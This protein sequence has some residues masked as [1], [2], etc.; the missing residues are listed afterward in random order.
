MILRP[1]YQ[2]PA[3]DAV[4]E[5]L[6]KHAST[7]LVMAT[8][9]GKCLA[10]GTKVLM[11]DGRPKCVEDIDVG[12]LL[13]GP[14]SLP[15]EVTTTAS[16]RDHMFQVT[17]KKGEP[18]TVNYD[19]V[20]CIKLTA[21]KGITKK[22]AGY[23][24]GD[25]IDM[26]LSELRSMSKTFQHCAKGF[27]VG[28]DFPERGLPI[29]PYWLGLWLGDGASK[30]SDIHNT[31]PEIENYLR[32]FGQIHGLNFRK[33]QYNGKCPVY[34][35][36]GKKGQ[37]SPL[38]TQLRSLG[39]LNN[40]HIP[41]IYKCNS[42]E[43][44]LFLLAGL[45]DSD[46]Y[47]IPGGG[48]EITVKQQVFAEDIAYLARSL[49][50]AAYMKL[51][52]A[53][54]QTGVEGTYFRVQI[55]GD[56]SVIPTLI[57]RKKSPVRRQKKDVLVHG[58]KSKYIGDGEYFGFT[59]DRDGR[60]LLGDFTVTH[61]TVIAAE[62]IKRFYERTGRSALFL[63]DRDHL[64]WQSKAAIE[65]H[66]GL[67]VGV[68]M[69]VHRAEHSLF[70]KDKVIVSTV[71][72]QISGRPKKR[73]ERF[74]PEEF[75][76]VI[77]DECHQSA[78]PTY[79]TIWNH[80]RQN[81]NI[82]LLGITAT[83]VRADGKPLMFEST[84]FQYGIH[85]GVEDGWLVDVAQQFI[86]VDSLDWSECR[87]SRN[88]EFREED[89]AKVVET[90][91]NIAGICHPSLEVIF[92]L[93]PETLSS[94]PLSEWP[95]FLKRLGKVP[96]RTIIFT[97]SV[98]QAE[99]CCHILNTAYPG[100]AE[101]V[102]GDT[103]PD[104]RENLLERFKDGR[105]AVV[106][107]VG[108]LCL[109]SE[110]EILT[111]DGWKGID[112]MS[113]NHLVANWDNGN[114]FFDA[115]KAII[116][117]QRGP[118][119]KMAFLQ[120]KNRSIRVTEDHAMIYRTGKTWIKVPASQLV[121]RAAMLP[122]SGMADPLSVSMPE[123]KR[124]GR[125]WACQRIAGN[126][127]ML[128]NN[129]G[130]GWDESITEAKK[131]VAERDSLNYIHPSAL[132]L[133]QCEFIGFW[134]GDGS[135][136]RL[137]RGGVTYSLCQFINC[138]K[139]V[140]RVDFLIKQCGFDYLRKQKDNVIE[141][142]LARGTGFGSQKR[143]GVF[144]IEPYLDKSGSQLLWGLNE[145]QF[146]AL[147]KGYWMA[148]GD[149][150]T[151]DTPQ[152][153]G[154]R[155]CGAR[156]WLLELIQSIACVRGYR[157]NL[158]KRRNGKFWLCYLSLRKETSHAMTKYR[159]EYESGWKSE[160]VWCVTSTSGNIITRRGGT[161]T[162]MGNCQGYDNPY[163]EVVIMARAIRSL[164]LYTQQLGRGTRTLPGLVDDPALTTALL[165]RQAIANSAKPLVR[166]VDFKG[167]SGRFKLVNSMHVLAGDVMSD[168]AIERA[169]N[170]AIEG[171]KPKRVLAAL[172]NAEK[173]LQAEQV[174]RNKE[175]ERQRLLKC[176]APKA[177][178][179]VRDVDAFGNESFRTGECNGKGEK[180]IPAW[181]LKKLRA[182]QMK[183]PVNY[184]QAM[185]LYQV[186]KR[187]EETMP[188]SER[189]KQRLTAIGYDVQ[190][191][192]QAKANRAWQ[193]YFVNDKQKPLVSRV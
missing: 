145:A 43:Q 13:M 157:A 58:I 101:W 137:A 68:E 179:R 56:C 144:P 99:E 91:E 135:V 98:K 89:V 151:N 131:R 66:T 190:G 147:V 16:G 31:D 65:E 105:T 35:N 116:R 86:K 143:K 52:K 33:R 113:S 141:W 130:F 164:T 92:G 174:E 41:W 172:S 126:A 38:I 177:S 170:D 6:T 84:C 19:H 12:D 47:L 155:I 161:V 175:I 111:S 24:Y 88:G 71:Q 42:R 114:V 118:I 67:S 96:R 69:N 152:N 178:Y 9:L 18:Y 93:E 110:T 27:R 63:A 57:A 87:V 187:R 153:V 46:G 140:D 158:K 22:L 166:I 20:L 74:R 156:E 191:W 183:Q 21:G 80:Y 10:R 39:V 36:S 4:G 192:T 17:P 94:Q 72:T 146:D 59:L 160:R 123:P 154:I 148:D 185:V 82:K 182:H 8:G 73:M 77:I 76:L 180:E 2:I 129:N 90:K 83:P 104:K 51:K 117:R 61:N 184:K 159:L 85:A 60:F 162:V 134:L 70:A 7:L 64:I 100:L 125:R 138:Q 15:R 173:K 188:I 115:P 119:E 102:C 121:G 139:I 149:H 108:V 167:N 122:I 150:G 54:C 127:Y 176:K 128:R 25:I 112:E 32:N 1:S 106:A 11:F 29:P 28:I 49:G 120:T 62:V 97:A 107:N 133:E 163:V 181:V 78:A 5:H 44:R 48:F 189:N 169:V 168:E 50:F 53:R 14:D 45:I 186:C 37:R 132:S 95:G 103:D 142:K 34:V 55:S 171:K 3:V 109:D 165:R 136:G 75:G 40:K 79:A 124:S 23:H 81:P 193:E 26:P 30:S